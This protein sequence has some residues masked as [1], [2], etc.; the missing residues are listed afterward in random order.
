MER[1][2]AAINLNDHKPS[3]PHKYIIYHS[4][5]QSEIA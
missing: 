4:P 2:D 3:I 1:T 5:E